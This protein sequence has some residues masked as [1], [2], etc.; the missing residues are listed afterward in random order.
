[1]KIVAVNIAF[2]T[3]AFYKRWRLLAEMYNDV[4]VTLIGPK[5][6]EYH[7]FGPVML[8]EPEP[9]TESKFKVRHVNMHRRKFFLNDWC[10]LEYLKILN[11]EKPD[12]VYL[13]GCET[14]NVVFL[15]ELYRKL[16]APKLK[17][18]LFTMRGIDMPMHT[19]GV[20]FLA[21]IH[22]KIRWQITKKIFDFVNV[23]YPHGRQVINQ[24]GK[25]LG[26][27][28]LQTQIGVNRDVYHP[29]DNRREQ[30]RKKYN[31]QKDDWVFC[32]AIR[33][34]KA[35]GVFDIISACK[36][37]REK[38]FKY[39]LMGN[40]KDFEKVKSVI[41]QGNLASKII[42]TDRVPPGEQVAAHLNA[43]D[44]FIHVPITTDNWVDTFPLAVVQG[45]ASG[46]P[47]IGSDSGAV[48]YQLGP[49]GIIVKEGNPNELAKMMIKTINEKKWAKKIGLKMLERVL[50]S[51]EIRHLNEYIY[52]TI[53][54]HLD[55]TPEKAP[56]D[57]MGIC[58]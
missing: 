17:I 45:M 7:K 18:A 43:S 29:D 2:R 25:Y 4:E 10:D 24:Q 16:F 22:Y 51:F 55:G 41:Q 33:I 37:I 50:N 27:V 46:L 21:K 23:H 58:T 56:K 47:V 32:S 52:Q 42:L 6:Y 57:Q 36:L 20:K 39:L 31:I 11:Q 30:I 44:C 14:D 3:E 28:Y 12:F 35:K 38:P 8:F 15:T 13:I 9:V 48:P 34:E 26:P 49:D 5:Y 19:K 53:K 54:A 1:M 40:G